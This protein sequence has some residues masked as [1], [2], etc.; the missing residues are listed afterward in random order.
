MLSQ[1][2]CRRVS[3][4][5][6]LSSSKNRQ[7]VIINHADKT[8]QLID[9]DGES[10]SYIPTKTALQFHNCDDKVR[11]MMGPYGSGKT[12]AM[13]ADILFR[14]T[15]VK[16]E[17]GKR[18]S[19]W[20][21][22]RNT[23]AELQTTTYVSWMAWFSLLGTVKR[24]KHPII[25]VNHIFNDG[26]GEVELEL[27][28]LPLDNE[29]AIRKLKSLEVT[30][31]YINETSEILQSVFE[32]ALAR[33]GRYRMNLKDSSNNW[34]GVIFDTNPPSE[35]HWIYK[36]FEV[37]CPE[38]WHLFKQ[39]PGLLSDEE[40]NWRYNPDADNI[41]RLKENY[42]MDMIHNTQEYINVF[43]L[44]NYGTVKSGKNVYPEYNDDIHSVDNI[45]IDVSQE[46]YIGIDFGL[47][48]AAVFL[49]K[50]GNGCYD[51]VHEIV[52]EQLGIE[53]FIDTLFS[54]FL[55]SHPGLRICAIIGD[56]SGNKRVDTDMRSCFDIFHKRGYMIQGAKSNFLTP[57]LEAVRKLLNGLVDGTP[58]LRVSKKCPTLREGFL[59]EYRYKRLRVGQEIAYD[60]SPE[61]NS[62]SHIHDALQYIALHVTTFDNISYNKIPVRLVKW[63]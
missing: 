60:E 47:T 28:F 56:P 1:A 34:N 54:Q 41:E 5:H 43:C 27:I 18:F 35:K 13:I 46:V 19:R 2:F 61:K 22:I 59:G 37:S 6:E 31:I 12:T 32:H 25:T 7:D 48:P 53:Q 24:N 26:N 50:R 57:R 36:R 55:S 23:Y 9:E 30:G 17:G 40:G 3:R 39:P 45:P 52:T 8:F 10:L 58:R 15:S 49:Q 16:A 14:A 29:S 38:G 63:R 62:H 33:I 51:V 44:G 21:V 11:G 42:Y 20:A 4:L